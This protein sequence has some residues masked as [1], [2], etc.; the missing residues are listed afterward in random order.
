LDNKDSVKARARKRCFHVLCRN[1]IVVVTG[2]HETGKVFGR[3]VRAFDAIIGI[4][5]NRK[6]VEGVV[7]DVH[8]IPVSCIGTFVIFIKVNRF[9]VTKSGRRSA[10]GRTQRGACWGRTGTYLLG[11]VLGDV[12][13][14]VIPTKYSK[15]SKQLKFT[16]KSSSGMMIK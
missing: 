5:M 14:G 8:M 11:D 12:T 4:S 2:I 9:E 10:W 16:V 1:R 13:D 3:C 6:I 15:L 7:A